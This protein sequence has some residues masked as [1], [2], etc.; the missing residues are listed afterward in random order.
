MMTNAV[1]WFEIPVSD[2]RRATK[3]YGEIFEV[4]LK[5]DPAM[6]GYEMSMFPDQGGVGGAL[7]YGPGY[8]P[9]A[10][11]S[12]VYLNG[13]DDLLPVLNRVEKAGGKILQNK[14]SIGKNGFMAYIEDSEGNKVGL[15]SLK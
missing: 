7:L 15:H 5:A 10:S 9:S 13:G 4:T 1:T 2:M 12:L 6:P 8:S 3:F 11:G 14:T